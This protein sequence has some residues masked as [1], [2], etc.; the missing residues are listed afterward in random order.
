M[1]PYFNTQDGTFH[2]RPAEARAQEAAQ[3]APADSETE[4]AVLPPWL[5]ALN[6]ELNRRQREREADEA[7]HE[8]ERT[9]ERQAHLEA[10]LAE[11]ESE[12]PPQNTREET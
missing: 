11:I 8:R 2:D 6:T 4:K 1:A 9:A 10:L 3:P 5:I 7:R 12:L